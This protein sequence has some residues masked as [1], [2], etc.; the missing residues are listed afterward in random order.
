[1]VLVPSREP[2]PAAPA[3]EGCCQSMRSGA[4]APHPA[5]SWQFAG[6]LL[7]QVRLLAESRVLC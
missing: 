6:N 1:M 4:G 2:S 3:G 5:W 7:A